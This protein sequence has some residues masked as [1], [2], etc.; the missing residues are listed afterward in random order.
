MSLETGAA[1]ADGTI[2]AGD[3]ITLKEYGTTHSSLP[4]NIERYLKA[5]A[6]WKLLRRDSSS[7]S[8]EQYQ[9]LIAIESQIINAVRTM[10]KGVQRIPHFGYDDWDE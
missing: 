2:A 6:V 3:Y 7:D 10:F 5:Y 4:A 8:A 9:E 1:M